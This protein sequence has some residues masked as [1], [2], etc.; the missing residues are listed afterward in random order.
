MSSYQD[1]PLED[2]FQAVVRMTSTCGGHVEAEAGP[3]HALAQSWFWQ[4][5]RGTGGLIM[6]CF[7]GCC[8]HQNTGQP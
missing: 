6:V 3:R 5:L 2:H 1:V 8:L 7:S 4:C